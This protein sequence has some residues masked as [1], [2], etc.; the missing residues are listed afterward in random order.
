MWEGDGTDHETVCDAPAAT[1][2]LCVLLAASAF[3]CLTT[4]P[5][6][7]RLLMRRSS[8]LVAVAGAGAPKPS[9]LKPSALKVSEAATL[10]VPKLKA[11]LSELG[12]PT[13]GLKAV[14]LER[15]Q[16]ALGEPAAATAAAPAAAAGAAPT[17]KT[18]ASK[19]AASKPPAAPTPKPSAAKRGPASPSAAAKRPKAAKAAAGG[20]VG[21]GVGGGDGRSKRRCTVFSGETDGAIAG[22]GA[23]EQQM[24]GAGSGSLTVA[25]TSRGFFFMSICVSRNAIGSKASFGSPAGGVVANGR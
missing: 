17:R 13:S 2:A 20:G 5:L 25:R 23:S 21:V 4:A 15:L 12:L 9:A 19:A 16:A 24:P 14:L 10:T 3:R 11:E 18:A 7:P 1:T 6:A 8:R 22:A